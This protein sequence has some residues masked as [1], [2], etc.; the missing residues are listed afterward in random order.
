MSEQ[1]VQNYLSWLQFHNINLTKFGFKLFL[2]AFDILNFG[3]VCS[4]FIQ[5]F[6]YYKKAAIVRRIIDYS[7]K[8]FRQ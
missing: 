3:A 4:Q 2:N 6:L 1:K 5:T 7:N 8:F